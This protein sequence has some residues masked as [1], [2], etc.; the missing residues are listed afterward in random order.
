[1]AAVAGILTLVGAVL[2]L[3]FGIVLLVAA[4]KK[5]VG[6]GFLSLC[7]PFYIFYFAFAK[8]ESPKRKMVLTLWL[9][10]M[11]IQIIGSILAPILATQGMQ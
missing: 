3:V 6:T 1:M 5:S 9:V 8:Y 10:G 4:F 2:S 11:G 7:I